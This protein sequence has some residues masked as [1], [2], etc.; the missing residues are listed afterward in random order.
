MADVTA[1][2]IAIETRDLLRKLVLLLTASLV[3]HQK[4]RTAFQDW[5]RLGE[6]RDVSADQTRDKFQPI[7]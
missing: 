1:R 5:T 4:L 2:D 7:N 3:E 6:P